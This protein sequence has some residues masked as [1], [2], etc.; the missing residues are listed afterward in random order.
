MTAWNK[1]LEVPVLLTAGHVFPNGVGSPV[2][3]FHSRWPHYR[4]LRSN[5]R[6]VGVVWEQKVPSGSGAGWDVAVIDC[7]HSGWPMARS[8]HENTNASSR[9]K[10]IRVHDAYSGLVTRAVVQGALTNLGE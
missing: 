3:Q 10:K 6:N 4:W 9:P 8:S 2:Y 1:R 7:L 5:V